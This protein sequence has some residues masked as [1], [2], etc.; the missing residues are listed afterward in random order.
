MRIKPFLVLSILGLALAGCSDKST[1]HQPTFAFIKDNASNDTPVETL[2]TL[3]ADISIVKQQ[4]Q[5]LVEQNKTLTEQD[6]TTLAQ[7]KKDLQTEV[8]TQLANAKA[9]LQ[10][11]SSSQSG[12]SSASSAAHSS[13]SPYVTNGSDSSNSA[14]LNTVDANGST[15]VNDLQDGNVNEQKSDRHA[16]HSMATLLNPGLADNKNTDD[17]GNDALTLLSEPPNSHSQT[18]KTAAVPYYTIP[19]NA[20]LTGAIAMQPIIGRIPIDGKVPDPYTFKAIIGAKNL[21]ANGIDVPPDI[22]GIVASGVAE[23]GMLGKCARGEI[24]SMTFVFQDGRISTTEAKSGQALGTIAAANGNPCIAGSFH[25][26]AALFL[27]ATA[28]LAGLQGYGNALSQAQLNTTTSAT[29]GATISS[30]IGS[31]N[32]FA[33]GQGFSAASQAAQKWWEQRVQNSFDFVYVPNVNP[34]TKKKLELNIN[35]TQEIPIDYDLKNRK[36]AYEHET[37]TDTIQHLD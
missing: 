27:G 8:D 9:T 31:A 28:G 16:A 6:K 35:V 4:N 1:S 36:V 3:T 5:Q 13:N 11:S 32:K 17:K 15:W 21:A 30:L 26:D 22:Q 34:K 14:T 20:T 25:T 24:T 37:N 23:G 18:N 29:T 10:Q 2:K 33:F 12:T 19:V 7:F